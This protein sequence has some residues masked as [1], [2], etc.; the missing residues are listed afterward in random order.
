MLGT[1][2]TLL[3][4]Y[5][6]NKYDKYTLIM[7]TEETRRVVE[8]YDAALQQIA[9]LKSENRSLK[10]HL[11]ENNVKVMRLIAH[12]Q[13]E[14]EERTN[15][16]SQLNEEHRA[17]EMYERKQRQRQYSD[18][19]TGIEEGD[20][21]SRDAELE[22]VIYML[23]DEIQTLKE[24]QRFQKE[25]FERKSLHNQA[26]AKRSFNENIDILRGLATDAVSADVADAMMDLL[27]DNE[28]LSN[29]FRDV[30]DEMERLQL[31]REELSKELRRARR[32][33]DFMSYRERLME[34]K[35]EDMKT[36]AESDGSTCTTD[37]M[38]GVA[39][40]SGSFEEY[41]KESLRLCNT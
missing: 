35:L 34:E 16:I 29:E 36:K 2:F 8:R 37:K 5:L 32:E 38:D 28:R 1:S 10:E 11:R 15:K 33:L 22:Q 30:L 27:R 39:M 41:F 18:K 20:F 14:I 7:L 9:H 6:T 24:D 25:E 26:L 40:A 21:N 12:Y 19:S 17:Q 31:S 13:E 4:I 3:A 23:E